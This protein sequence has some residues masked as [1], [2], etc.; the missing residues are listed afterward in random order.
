MP[1]KTT[2]EIVRLDPKP[3]QAPL[4]TRTPFTLIGHGFGEGME[5][6]VSTKE[7]GSDRVD[8]EVLP[9]DSATSTDKVW[10]VVAK[11]ALGAKPTDTTKKPRDSR[12]WIV[13]KLNGQKSAI[14]GFLIV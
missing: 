7:D 2:L 14:Q 11:P 3:V 12:L 1:A 4:R 10:P 13:I 8:V 9:D 5:V 6:Y